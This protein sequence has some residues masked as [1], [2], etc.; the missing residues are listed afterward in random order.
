[1]PHVLAGPM[2]DRLMPRLREFFMLWLDAYG[3]VA[4]LLNF[5]ETEHGQVEVSRSCLEEQI[6]NPGPI[7]VRSGRHLNIV[8]TR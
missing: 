2:R 1:M 5:S 8:R 4:P 3:R 6:P 7:R